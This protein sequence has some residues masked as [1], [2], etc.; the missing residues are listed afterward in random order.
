MA[1]TFRSLALVA[2][3]V[4]AG[5]VTACAQTGTPA[6]MAA[7]NQPDPVV[8]M[9][10]VQVTSPQLESGCW[11]QFYDQRNFTGEVMTLIGPAE[12]S[13]LDKGTGRELKRDIDSLVVGP[14]ALLTVYQH[15]AFR[16]KAVAFEPNA[17][18]GGLIQKL[19]FG[20]RIESMRL[21]CMR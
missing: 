15:Q 7:P 8:L 21:D 11:A 4:A 14:K 3:C 20:G 18:E 2:A 1:L 10:P 12:L 17:R 6:A 19:G 5:V 9:V 13:A 16:D